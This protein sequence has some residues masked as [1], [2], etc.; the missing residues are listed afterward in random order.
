[1]NKTLIALIL[2]SLL[3]SACAEKPTLTF[4]GVKW[5]SNRA[6]VREALAARHWL[7]LGA[8]LEFERSKQY[9]EA[10]AQGCLIQVS[11]RES[12]VLKSGGLDDVVRTCTFESRPTPAV[13]AAHFKAARDA[14]ATTLGKP[15]SQTYR[16]AVWTG[17]DGNQIELW[18]F[19]ADGSLSTYYKPAMPVY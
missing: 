14:L 16:S 18:S 5:G 9:Q 3:G 19:V 15:S 17:D 12:Y 2:A 1:M 7:Y 4:M 8:H 6:Q 10:T 11:Y 13:V